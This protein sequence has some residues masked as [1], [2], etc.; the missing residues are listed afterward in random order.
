MP[1]EAFDRRLVERGG[2]QH[3]FADVRVVH[4]VEEAFQVVGRDGELVRPWPRG[5]A[6][7]GTAAGR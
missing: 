4:G 1:S 7:A 2:G 5:R 6:G 3:R